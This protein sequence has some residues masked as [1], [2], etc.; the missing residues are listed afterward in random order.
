MAKEDVRKLSKD[1]R[2]KLREEVFQVYTS[3][4][5]VSAVAR[6][7]GVNRQFV[8]RCICRY[9]KNKHF[10]E[11]RRW[12]GTCSLYNSQFAK[13]IEDKIF[14]TT[15]NGVGVNTP[16]WTT[17]TVKDLIRNECNIDITPYSVR[18]LLREYGFPTNKE[19]KWAFHWSRKA[20]QDI[21]AVQYA[22]NNNMRCYY[23]RL[24]NNMFVT[25]VSTRG[26][27]RFVSRNHKTEVPIVNWLLET[28]CS[29]SKKK[30]LVI[31]VPNN[32]TWDMFYSSRIPSS[33]LLLSDF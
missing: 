14:K 12:K 24:I 15:P 3:V 10:R 9:R 29:R 5:D 19:V 2:E 33:V 32:I 25:V 16:L 30:L 22:L 26:D 23:L 17:N 11:N 1:K 13:L 20:T 4:R 31:Y 18:K 7:L 28:L 21:P 6:R 8:Y 27:I